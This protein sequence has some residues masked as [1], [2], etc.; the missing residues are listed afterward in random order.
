M[1]R[2]VD[3]QK[4]IFADRIL[5]RDENGSLTAKSLHRLFPVDARMVVIIDDRGDVWEWSKS[6]IKVVPYD[7]FKGIGDIN[8]SFLPKRQD[9][10]PEPPQPTPPPAAPAPETKEDPGKAEEI[11]PTSNQE[12]NVASAEAKPEPSAIDK[13]VTMGGAGDAAT[14]QEKVIEQ[15]EQL[16]SQIADRPLLQQQLELEHEEEQAE[17]DANAEENNGDSTNKE[18]PESPKP[19]HNLL[20]D[21]DVELDNL[22]RALK[23]VH[24]HFYATYTASMTSTV[25]GGRISQLKGERSPKKKPDLEN[26]SLVP[27]VQTIMPDMKGQVLKGCNLVFSGVIPLSSRPEM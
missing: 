6:L 4:K 17:S 27:D 16:A 19:R 24:Q 3:P 2:I 26:M 13:L 7:F 8:S 15:D 21:D 1:A 5:S 9:I 25:G 22:E 14:L 18:V 10:V 23:N 11:A 20:K 12:D